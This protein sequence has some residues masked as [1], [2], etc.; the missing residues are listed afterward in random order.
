M[1]KR[2]V[3]R[4]CSMNKFVLQFNKLLFDCNRSEDTTEFDT[5]LYVV[6]MY[7]ATQL[8]L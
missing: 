6:L 8:M 1:P 4:N 2:F 3:P 7:A 5:K